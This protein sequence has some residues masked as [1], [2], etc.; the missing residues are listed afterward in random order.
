MV[1]DRL[2]HDALA[3]QNLA[4]ELMSRGAQVRY[5]GQQISFKLD[6]FVSYG[7]SDPITLAR[8]AIRYSGAPH[9]PPP[10]RHPHTREEG[11]FECRAPIP[12]L[13]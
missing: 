10:K 1:G 5:G 6:A 13:H 4:R 7:S 2:F 11:R 9:D 8:I 12:Q 3:A